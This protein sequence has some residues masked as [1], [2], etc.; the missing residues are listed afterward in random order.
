MDIR[1]AQPF[2]QAEDYHQKYRLKYVGVVYEDFQR[3]Y[4]DHDDIVRSTAAARCNGIIS[5][6][7]TRDE[8]GDEIDSYGLTESALKVLESYLR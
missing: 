8:L 2:Y 4:P 1:E 3:M 6:Y 5:G 7:G